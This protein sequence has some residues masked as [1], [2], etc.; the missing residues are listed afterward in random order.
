MES[1]G[2]CAPANATAHKRSGR[3]ASAKVR[4]RKAHKRFMKDSRHQEIWRKRNSISAN[5]RPS[6][7]CPEILKQAC[8]ITIPNRQRLE[9]SP[10]YESELGCP[11]MLATA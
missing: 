3:I 1:E 6:F 10:N 2:C 5:S 8:G 9:Q 11:T 7:H 4:R